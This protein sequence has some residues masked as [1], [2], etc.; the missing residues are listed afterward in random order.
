MALSD[1]LSSASRS[2]L[3]FELHE[4][5]EDA[6]HTFVENIMGE[7]YTTGFLEIIGEME[8]VHY[9]EIRLRTTLAAKKLRDITVVNAQIRDEETGITYHIDR[10]NVVII[11]RS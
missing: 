5:E 11:H 1:F 3:Q 8:V 4:L 6:L 2:L 7:L 9:D 10:M